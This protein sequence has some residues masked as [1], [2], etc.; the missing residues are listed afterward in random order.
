[1]RIAVLGVGLIGGSIGLAARR[2]LDSE[3][4]GWDRRA[5]PYLAHLDGVSL[6]LGGDPSPPPGWEVVVLPCA[7]ATTMDGRSSTSSASSSALFFTRAC[8]TSG[9]SGAIALDATISAPLGTLAASW[10]ITTGM[11]AASRRS[12]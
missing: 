6:D 3:V 5:T 7:P 9:L 8:A 4:A 10:P 2:R 11:P 12:T 1:M